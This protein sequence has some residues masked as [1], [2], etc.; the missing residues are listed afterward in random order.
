MESRALLTGVPFGATTQDTAEF[1]LG[2]VHVNIVFLES[3]GQIDASTEDWTPQ[4]IGEIKQKVVEGITWWEDALATL[5]SVHELNFHFDFTFADSPFQTAYEPISRVSQD[6]PLWVNELLDHVG[7]GDLGAGDVGITRGIR[8]F[9]HAERVESNSNWG[10]TLFVVDSENDADGRF[11]SGS[12]FS[13]AFAFAGGLFYISPSQRPASTFAHE[14]GHIFYALDEH[15]GGSPYTARRGYYNTQ[16]LNASRQH[17]DPESRVPS[18]MDNHVEAFP[19][20]AISQSGREMVGWRDSD[21]DGIFDV[22]DVPLSLTGS[23]AVDPATGMY[24]FVGEASVGTLRNMNPS[25]FRSDITIN[26]V[27]RVQYRIDGGAWSDA[28]SPHANTADLDFSFPVPE[29]E[30]AV[31]IRALDDATNEPGESGVVSATFHATTTAPA[32]TTA[33]GVNGFLWNDEDGDGVRDLGEPS[34]AGWTVEVRGPAGQALDL[35]QRV[36][37]DNYADEADILDVHPDVRLTA[38]GTSVASNIASVRTQTGASTGGKVFAHQPFPGGPSGWSTEWIGTQRQFMMDFTEP[39]TTVSIDVVATSDG[40]MGRLELYDENFQ[41]IDRITTQ[42]LAAGETATLTFGAPTAVIKRA[43]AGGHAESAVLLDNLRFGPATTTTTDANGAWSLPHLD[44]GSFTVR[45]NAGPAWQ[46]TTTGGA[47]QPVTLDSGAVVEDVTFG[48]QNVGSVWHN[49]ERPPDVNGDGVVTL[50]DL[51]DVTK[52]LR[53]SGVGAL[54][55]E[56]EE[57][58]PLIDADGNG[59]ASLNDLLVVITELRRQ[60]EQQGSGEGESLL[61]SE[62]AAT[63]ASPESPGEDET[64]DLI[65]E[66]DLPRPWFVAH[67]QFS[68]QRAGAV[69]DSGENRHAYPSLPPLVAVRDPLHRAAT[70]R[71]AAIAGSTSSGM[72]DAEEES[73]FD[74]L[75]DAIAPDVARRFDGA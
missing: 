22:L 2:D 75:L 74:S 34:L 24:R 8:A 44:S 12:D 51:L 46:A 15:G 29:G 23:G 42:P 69:T 7:F 57:G 17:P 43:V 49:A 21:G 72:T 60:I 14:V 45:V 63:A 18:I 33:P 59:V 30:H 71:G 54:E 40:D 19:T 28:V 64:D 32:A 58:R 3:N 6:F 53:N 41:L 13:Q 61:A 37:P 68:D 26:E 62:S 36:E 39:V 20:L 55:G 67:S 52:H 16:N 1:L 70:I 56:P 10:F 9:N 65:M 11:A 48:F 50:Q 35:Q 25:G 4:K 27:S 38:T 31:E 66:N 47:S 73:S 5:G